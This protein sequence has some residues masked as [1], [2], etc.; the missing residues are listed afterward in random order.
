MTGAEAAERNADN[1]EQAVD[2]E[3]RIQAAERLALSFNAGPIPLAGPS[4]PPPSPTS[5]TAISEAILDTRPTA[6]TT[7]T[8]TTAHPSCRALLDEEEEGEGQEEEIVDDPPPP[9]TAPAAMTQ[10]RAGRK[11][12]PTMKALEAEKMPKRDTGQA[13]GRG[14]GRGGKRANK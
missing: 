14:R 10:S 1:R 4:P 6:T 7:T 8:T 5:T 13:K 2:R 11:R 9:S 12:A 3:A